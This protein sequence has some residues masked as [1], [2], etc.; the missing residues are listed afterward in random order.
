MPRLLGM[1]TEAKPNKFWT[2]NS[3]VYSAVVLIFLII[4]HL[5]GKT[6][7]SQAYIMIILVNLFMLNK[8]FQE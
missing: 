6:F 5:K 3:V 4:A 8:S 2:Y 1:M 7:I